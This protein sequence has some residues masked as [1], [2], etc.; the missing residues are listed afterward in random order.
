MENINNHDNTTP[1]PQEPNGEY[2]LFDQPEQ[3]DTPENILS[4]LAELSKVAA[5]IGVYFITPPEWIAKAAI[6]YF[7]NNKYRIGERF[8]QGGARPDTAEAVVADYG[9]ALFGMNPPTATI[10]QMYDALKAV[11]PVS[12]FTADRYVLFLAVMRPYASIIK[13]Q[14]DYEKYVKQEPQP[15]KRQEWFDAE[16]SKLAATEAVAFQWMQQNGRVV[17]SDFAGVEQDAI[18]NFLN[19]MEQKM[20]VGNYVRYYAV[21]KFALCSPPEQLLAIEP[22]R[23]FPVRNIATQ[24]VED[25]MAEIQRDFDAK[26]AKIAAVVEK[27]ATGETPPTEIVKEA[28]EATNAI[29]RVPEKFAL[30][31]SRDLYTADGPK[32]ETILPISRYIE[33]YLQ[34]RKADAVYITTNM[35]E[36]RVVVTPRIV[37]KV[38]EGVNLLL[39]F[40]R[41]T[42]ENGYYRVETNLTEL[43]QLCGYKAA[44]EDER[45][46]LLAGLIILNGLYL[47]VWRSNG[48]EAVQVFDVPKFGLS[49]GLKG[50]VVILVTAEA[51]KGKPQLVSMDDYFRLRQITKGAAQNH[52][53]FQTFAKGQ[54]EETA[55]VD[56]VFGYKFKRDELKDKPDELAKANEY[57]RKHRARDTKTLQKW[58]KEYADM[59]VISYTRKQN[60]KG[61]WIYRWN[62]L[63]PP[64]PE[65]LAEAE[66]NKI[67]SLL[68]KPNDGIPTIANK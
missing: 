20:Y 17:I 3:A 49:G 43:S 62:R 13:F 12:A 35:G 51:I 22:P 57:I 28:R 8:V 58:F 42:P 66:R 16:P 56:E 40:N 1:T 60:A 53:R 19:R 41:V 14:G 15:A 33:S 25:I 2:T 24:Y 55:L 48:R 29:V 46:Q 18:R 21:A 64:T 27:S 45:L 10:E 52:F 50:N 44:N 59:G 6:N 63:K 39:T 23:S 4:E 36:T 30:L 38:I 68:L 9:R 31:L 11:N 54:C 5:Q 65:E 34:R 61:Q 32:A 47:V 26:A 37:E 67:E 7:N